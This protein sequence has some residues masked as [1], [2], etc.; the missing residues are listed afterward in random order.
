MFT[1]IVQEVGRIK[2]L[3]KKGRGMK[4]SVA[5]AGLAKP[6]MNRI[7]KGDSISVNGV[8]LTVIGKEPKSSKVIFFDVIPE[9][10]SKTNIGNLKIGEL[11]NI[12]QSLRYDD[13][14]DGHIV[15]GHVQGVGK[16]QEI[17]VHDKQKSLKSRKRS[18]NL[19]KFAKFKI[20]CGKKCKNLM[21]CIIPKGSIA[22]E[23]VSLT[24]VDVNDK[25][26]LFSVEL[27]PYTL[28]NTNLGIKK[29]GD[30]INIETDILARYAERFAKKS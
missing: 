25:E 21:K 8:C 23:G 1:G 18:G 26:N 12:E 14:F 30:I 2:G 11:V 5:I 9:T 15:Q 29:K 13:K 22:I 17:M 10:L 4:I 24:V 19:V 27:I 20:S 6:K 7:K 16:I 28:K 3:E